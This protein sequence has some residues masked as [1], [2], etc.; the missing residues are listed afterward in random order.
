MEKSYRDALQQEPDASE[1]NHPK[2]LKSG[3]EGKK[4]RFVVSH[5]PWSYRLLGVDD[6]EKK[7]NGVR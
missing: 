3:I 2:G 5:T 1:E 4:K 6:Q 7:A